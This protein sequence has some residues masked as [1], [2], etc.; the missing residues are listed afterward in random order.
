MY[1]IKDIHKVSKYAKEQWVEST[2]DTE[3]FAQYKWA[4]VEHPFT[5]WERIV[6]CHVK[7]ED[8]KLALASTDDNTGIF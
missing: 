1:L 4:V 5:N 6:S 7:Y 2:V 3:S 8:A